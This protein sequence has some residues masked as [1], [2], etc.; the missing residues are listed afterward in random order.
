MFIGYNIV[1]ITILHTFHI[2]NCDLVFDPTRLFKVKSDCVNRKPMAAFRKV[3]LV[4]CHHFQGISN[5]RIVS[6]TFNL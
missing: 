1:T 3:L 4:V 5:Q 2:N 6:L